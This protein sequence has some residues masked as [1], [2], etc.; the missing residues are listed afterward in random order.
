MDMFQFV[1]PVVSGGHWDRFCYFAVVN[2]VSLTFMQHFSHEYLFSVLWPI[3]S[4]LQ[5]VGQI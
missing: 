3:L 2:W 1:Y 5:L 4:E